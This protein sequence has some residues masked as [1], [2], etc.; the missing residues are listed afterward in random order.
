MAK[1]SSVSVNVPRAGAGAESAPIAVEPGAVKL[2]ISLPAVPGFF[3]KKNLHGSLGHRR[4]GTWYGLRGGP[5]V[6][7]GSGGPAVWEGELELPPGTE[8]IRL[9]L[10]SAD[11][12]GKIAGEVATLTVL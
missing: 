10:F 3:P 12:A 2:K 8:A 9:E 4:K 6:R 5:D 11:E 1:T 7:S